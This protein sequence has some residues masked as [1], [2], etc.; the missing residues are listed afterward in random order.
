[1]KVILYIDG[2]EKILDINFFPENG[3]IDY[4]F[5]PP[6]STLARKG[7]EATTKSGVKASF[8]YGGKKR[9]GCFLFEYYPE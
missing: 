3:R 1:M 2:W 6:I 9:R 8:F 5:F 4:G 7:E